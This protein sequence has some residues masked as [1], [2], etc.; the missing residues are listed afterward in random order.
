MNHY[1]IIED[2]GNILAIA[3]Y[4]VYAIC[5]LTANSPEAAIT[6]YRNAA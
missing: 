1:A 5:H 3:G 2:N 6:K 4:Y